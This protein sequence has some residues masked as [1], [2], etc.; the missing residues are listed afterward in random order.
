MVNKLTAAS[1]KIVPAPEFGKRGMT[2]Q[3]LAPPDSSREAFARLT[4]ETPRHWQKVI[5]GAKITPQ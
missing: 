2:A 3:A 5:E 1:T 4:R